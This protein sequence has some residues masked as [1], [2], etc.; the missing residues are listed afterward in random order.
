MNDLWNDMCKGK[1]KLDNCSLY[2]NHTQA[3]K[4]PDNSF[5]M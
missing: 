5:A 3:L 4:I 2:S 1:Y